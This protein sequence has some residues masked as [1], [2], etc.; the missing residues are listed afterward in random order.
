MRSR[1]TK[2]INWFLPITIAV[3][4]LIFFL[5]KPDNI[6]VILLFITLIAINISLIISQLTKNKKFGLI[7]VLL[8]I[9][10]IVLLLNFCIASSQ[11]FF[12][13]YR[14]SRSILNLSSIVAL[15]GSILLIF[16]NNRSLPKSKYW[17]L[18]GGFFTVASVLH[19]ILLYSF[20][21][22]GF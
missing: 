8:I 10:P 5:I 12:W 2:K 1:Q 4:L 17:Y 22:I 14:C 21:N 15:F 18:I 11:Y 20:S 19:L 6:A 9:L 3:N 16:L 13:G 7:L